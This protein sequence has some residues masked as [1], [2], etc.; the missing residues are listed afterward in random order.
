MMENQGV[1]HGRRSFMRARPPV[2]P[3]PKGVFKYIILQYL[4]DRP[5]H[6]YEI[7][8]ALEERFHGLYVPSAGTIYPRLQMLAEHGYVTATEQEGKKV[9]AITGEGLKFLAEH[10]EL[11]Q[12]INNHLNEWFNPEHIDD[13]KKT[14]LEFGR[15][16]E[17]FM[18]KVRQM[19]ST[20]LEHLREVLSRAYQDIED[21]SKE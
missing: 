8:R 18:W 13:R 2:G 3:F 14:M 21:M 20:K 16:T 5:Q 1:F 17:L 4:K 11:G 10:A 7:I 6:G 9:Y 15:L 19:D 12:T